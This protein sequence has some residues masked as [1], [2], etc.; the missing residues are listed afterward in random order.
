MHLSRGNGRDHCVEFPEGVAPR[1]PRASSPSAQ[2]LATPFIRSAELR[3][4]SGRNGSNWTPTASSFVLVVGVG[5]LH[6]L[7]GGG[8][9]F[10]GDV[11]HCLLHVRGQPRP[12]G[13]AD[14]IGDHE[15]AEADAVDRSF[16]SLSVP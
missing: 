2:A 7:A 12:R 1:L 16:T 10:L 11:D 14:G 5:L 13:V 9:Q 6:C 8:H 15:A 4:A 3:L